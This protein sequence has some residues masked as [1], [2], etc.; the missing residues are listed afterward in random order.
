MRANTH[1]PYVHFFSTW[2]SILF[3]RV[4]S[5]NTEWKSESWVPEV[6]L[7]FLNFLRGG[8]L[9]GGQSCKWCVS[10]NQCE[11]EERSKIV[12]LPLTPCEKASLLKCYN[13]SGLFI[14]SIRLI[15]MQMLTWGVGVHLYVY[16]P[17]AFCMSYELL[18]ISCRSWQ[19]ACSQ[20]WRLAVDKEHSLSHQ[21]MPALSLVHSPCLWLIGPSGYLYSG[22]CLYTD[23]P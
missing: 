5:C 19:S 14:T 11:W 23:I 22:G 2:I 12:I 3:E 9:P 13:M 6:A 10:R 17:F 4:Y 7:L 16:I 15:S 18:W 21:Y 8:W 20:T 1:P